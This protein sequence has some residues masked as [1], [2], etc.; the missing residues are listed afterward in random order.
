MNSLALFRVYLGYQLSALAHSD[1]GNKVV[2]QSIPSQLYRRSRKHRALIRFFKRDAP[3]IP[4]VAVCVQSTITPSSPRWRSLDDT[5]ACSFNDAIK[6][7]ATVAEQEIHI[8]RI[9]EAVDT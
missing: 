9:S 1:F 6:P 8:T 2:D 7:T 3:E 4:D 5:E